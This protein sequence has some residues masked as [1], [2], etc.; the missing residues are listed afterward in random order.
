MTNTARDMSNEA[1]PEIVI[2]V[3]LN[4]TTH[5]RDL[6]EDLVV[7]EE[8]IDQYLIEAP[9]KTAWWHHLYEQQ[10]T[11][12]QKQEV[13]I[14][15]LAAELDV[16]FRK[17]ADDD[18]RRV[19]DKAIL[20]LIKTDEEYQGLEDELLEMK[21]TL[22][23]LKAAVAAIGELRSTLISLSANMRTQWKPTNT[24]R[25]TEATG[26]AVDKFKQLVKDS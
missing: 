16:K 25:P 26:S 15:R 19:T 24:K 13:K 12:C 2:S 17:E 11:R 4:G 7:D 8:H 21:E 9:G 1:V 23:I 6:M 3:E 10:K 5:R 22:N 18:S 14:E 20:S